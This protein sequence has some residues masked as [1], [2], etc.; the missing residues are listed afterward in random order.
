MAES[1]ESRATDNETSCIPLDFSMGTGGQ[2]FRV[3]Q[4]FSLTLTTISRPQRP[5]LR[6]VQRIELR[7]DRAELLALRHLA[8]DVVFI[9]I[10]KK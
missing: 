9:T 3:G 5:S 2:A 4:R 10:S 8:G 6:Q 7:H 1:P